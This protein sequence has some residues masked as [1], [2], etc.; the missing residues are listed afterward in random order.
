MSTDGSRSFPTL[1]SE[2]SVWLRGV[3]PSDY[4]GMAEGDL[5]DRVEKRLKAIGGKPI[6]TATA[7]GLG[8]DF[9][10]DII[11]GKKASVRGSKLEQ[12]ANALQTT[13][14]YLLGE[15]GDDE[16]PVRRR[17]VPVIGYAGADQ[18]GRIV[19]SSSDPTNE[20]APVPP[21]GTTD[22]VA[23][24]LRG[25][26]MRGTADD[27]SLIYFEHQQNPPTPDMIGY[28]NMVELEDGRVLFKRLL[29]G[30]E[31]GLYDLESTT[32]DTIRDV[33]IKWAAEPTAIIPPRQA[34]RIV[35]RAD[36]DQAA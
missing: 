2:I 33:R 34:R 16:G 7:A 24:H 18:E 10:T 28:P 15:S 32:G 8:R 12:L 4:S 22:S 35:R 3:C 23:M 21:G 29:R 1:Q 19:H 14:Q 31:Q 25:V 6:P 11:N 5:K 27:G 13:T 26:S 20:F 17:E 9:I 36:E 30:S